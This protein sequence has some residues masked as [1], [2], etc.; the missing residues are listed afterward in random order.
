M[1]KFVLCV[2]ALVLITATLVS[3]GDEGKVVLR[4]YNWQEYMDPEVIEMFEE[5]TGIKVLYNVY[6]TNENMYNKIKNMKNYSYDVIFPSDYMI[7]RMADEGMLAEINFDNIPNYQYIDDKYKNMVYDKKGL[8]SVPYIG[9]TVCIA[10]NPDYVS[11]DDV[12]SWSVLWNEKYAK[13][14]FMMESERDS[15]AV[16][17]LKLGYSINTK[18]IDELNEAKVALLEQKPLVLAYTSDDVKEKMANEEGYLAVMWSCDITFVSDLNPKIQFAIPDEGTNIWWDA[19]C[20]LENAKYKTEAE[21]FINFLCRPEI[22][23]MNAEYLES[24]TPNKEAYTRLDPSVSGNAIIYPSDEV[25][26][27]SEMF[28]DL[29]DYMSTYSSIWNEVIGS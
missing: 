24:A 16:A 29:S 19:V 12:K 7:K 9:G 26:A 1:K 8:F 13:D 20:I 2:F 15:I 18:N 3:C 4:V 22:A 6:D 11:A 10:Y 23:L 28:E 21:E 17:L 14:I 5:E 27:K 25:I